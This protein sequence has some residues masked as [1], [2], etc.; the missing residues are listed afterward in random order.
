MKPGRTEPIAW[1]GKNSWVYSRFSGLSPAPPCRRTYHTVSGEPIWLHRASR[2]KIFAAQRR[3]SGISA[4]NAHSSA[5]VLDVGFRTVATSGGF[6]VPLAIGRLVFDRLGPPRH[7]LLG[8]G[9]P[10]GRKRHGVIGE[11]LGKYAVHRVGPT[12][13]MLNDFVGHMGHLETRCFKK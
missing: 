7:A 5:G 11:W 6:A 3:I 8:G 12:A 10:C 9:P 4:R 2:A 1:R 13:I